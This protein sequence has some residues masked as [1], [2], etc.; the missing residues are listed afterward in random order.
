[1]EVDGKYE[2]T[3]QGIINS[4]GSSYIPVDL[5]NHEGTYRIEVDASISSQEYNDIGYVHVTTTT[6]R[7]Y[8]YNDTNRVIYLSGENA[9]QKN[10][11]V[12][13]GGSVYYVHMGYSKMVEQI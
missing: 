5:T 8:Y 1:M 4:T 9:S 11:I 10:N 2:S 12:V 3:N 6:D 7:C 13:E